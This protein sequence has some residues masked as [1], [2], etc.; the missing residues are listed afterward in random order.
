MK[1]PVVY[2][3][4]F[5]PGYRRPVLEALNKALDERLIVCSGQPPSASFASLTSD[6]PAEYRQIPLRSW[7]IAGERLHAQPVG[8]VLKLKPSVILAE[9]SPRTI[10]LPVLLRGA[11]RKG[12]GTL[13]WGHFSSN[14]RPFGSSHPL[15]RYRLALARYADGCVCYTESIRTSLAEHVP[16][17]RLFTARNTLDIRPLLRL[18]EL[19]ETEGKP[20]VRRR[21]GLSVEAP[22]VTY[23][24]RL[25]PQKRLDL[26]LDTYSILLRHGPVSLVIVGDGPEKPALEARIERENWTDVR[27]TGAIT[28]QARSAPYLFASDVMVCPGYVGLA[29]NHAFALGLPVVTHASPK[30]GIRHHSPEVT[31]LKHGHNGLMVPHGSVPALADAVQDILADQAQYSARALSYA[32]THLDMSTMVDGLVKA[33]RFAEA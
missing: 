13:L 11:R 30:P 20:A 9:E 17:D 19:L 4:R 31:Y 12:T 27:L 25:I 16:S 18:R 28:G 6:T 33:V 22:V 32:R 26:L 15:D 23:I 2:V 21:L 1:R 24:G 29:V 5:V 14:N 10:T 8:Q 3:S 7:W